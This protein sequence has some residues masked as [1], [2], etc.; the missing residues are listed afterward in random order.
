MTEGRVVV[1]GTLSL[2]I[3]R[4]L[5]NVEP[6]KCLTRSK[7]KCAKWKLNNQKEG[8]KEI[9]KPPFSVM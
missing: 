8:K 4:Y 1:V 9:L 2:G 6:C 5:L 7:H 3:L